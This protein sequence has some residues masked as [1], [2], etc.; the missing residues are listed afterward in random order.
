MLD[1]VHSKA[2]SENWKELDVQKWLL[3]PE[4]I[5]RFKEMDY[6]KTIDYPINFSSSEIDKSLFDLSEK[7][8][9]SVNNDSNDDKLINFPVGDN[10]NEDE[11]KINNH[12]KK[13]HDEHDKTEGFNKDHHH[14]NH[15][16]TKHHHCE[17][18]QKNINDSF[19]NDIL[20]LKNHE[21]SCNC[22]KD[23]N[24]PC[25]KNTIDEIKSNQKLFEKEISNKFDILNNQIQNMSGNF[26]ATLVDE[27]YRKLLFDNQT[28]TIKNY[29]NER[30]LNS[31]FPSSS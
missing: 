20:V 15:C 1:E 29:L 12:H 19:T 7:H 30:I 26:K 10:D 18:K 11:H 6:D 27:S 9:D 21:I 4:N 24:K 25:E 8:L 31:Q 14:H 17:C 22:K 2:I 13:H 5:N 3:N 16:D 23:F 28:E